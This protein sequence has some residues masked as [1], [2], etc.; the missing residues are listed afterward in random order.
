MFHS[1]LLLTL[2]LLGTAAPALRAA[3]VAPIELDANSTQN[4]IQLNWRPIWPQAAWTISSSEEPGFADSLVLATVQMPAWTWNLLPGERQRFFR[5]VPAT[6]ELP[7][8]TTIE[9]FEWMPGLQSWAQEDLAPAGWEQDITQSVDGSASLHLFGNTVKAQALA[10]AA[11]SLDEVWRVSAQV[12]GVADRQMVG[13][14]DSAN[15]MWYVLWGSRG[16]YNDTPGQSGQEEVSCYQGWFPEN[17]WV[18][19]LLPVGQDWVGKYG[20]LPRLCHVVWANESDDDTGEVWFDDLRRVDPAAAAPL[21]DARWESLGQVGDSLVVRLWNAAHSAEL[22]ESWN[23]GDGRR[24]TGN[25]LELRLAA[26]R[27]HRV[28]LLT[29]DPAG[30][31]DLGSLV[32]PGQAAERRVRLTFGGDVMTARVYENPGGIIETQGVDAIFDSLRADLQGADLAIVNLECPYTTA[33]TEHPTKSITFKSRPENLV[34]VKNAGVDAVSLA[35]NHVFDWLE[36]GLQ[37]TMDGLT[38]LDL[39]GTGAGMNS[40][41]ARRPV[42]LSANGLA[43]GVAGFCDRTGNYN[44]AQPFLEAGLSRPGFAMWS[45]GDMQTLI[46]ALRD[47]VDLLVLQVHSGNEYSTQPSGSLA[48]WPE[49]MGE[50]RS[51]LP[52]MDGPALQA[53]EGLPVNPELRGLYARELLPDQTERA[54][55]HEAVDLGARLVVTHHPHIVQGFEAYHGGLIAHSLGN[56]VMDLSYQETMPSVLLEVEDDGQALQEAW[57]K[58]VFIEGYKPRICR[59]ETAGLLLDHFARISRPFDT[60]VLRQPGAGQAWIA[61]DTTSLVFAEQSYQGSLPLE[62]R[63][64]WYTS[65]PVLLDGEG[66][67]AGLLSTA[68][69]TGLQIR[70]GRNQCWWGNMED[71]G[72]GIWDINSA[73]EGFVGD[74]ARRGERSL[75]LADAGTTVY[76]YYTVR[77]PLDLESEW[78]LCGWTRSQNATSTNLQARY[79]A[80]RTSDLLSA[81]NTASVAG[82]QDWTWTWLD[83]NPPAETNF[84]QFRLAL[85]AP[86]AGA[87]AWFDD[88]T[89]VEW[90]SWQDLTAQQTLPVRTPNDLQWVQVRLPAATTTVPLQWSRKVC[91]NPPGEQAAR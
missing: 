42:A 87:T 60:W 70:L 63:S 68:A 25:S 53:E 18:E 73:Q 38:A 79:Y 56:L 8:A 64:G 22:S 77:A 51:R 43:V 30:R 28:T 83:L 74:V 7:V 57:L 58:P 39:P 10:G 2:C 71:E 4:Q 49:A 6:G 72:A 26:A 17:Q 33:E 67:L 13:V 76:T 50:D 82:T 85:Q 20:Y 29:E 47:Q 35:N 91:Q 86:T 84:Y 21:A 11:L 14:A 52:A 81:V 44:N 40:T 90:D 46:P 16:G 69:A 89:L 41:R 75:R 36:A 27:S 80:T 34:G 59:G 45:R 37:E 19:A 54:L 62:L 61:L 15:V 12:V 55:R 65:P 5:V 48:L 78:S 3:C 88:V 24:V 32:V 9:S 1:A 23:L 31:W 66:E